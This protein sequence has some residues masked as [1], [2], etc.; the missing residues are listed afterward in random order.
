MFTVSLLKYWAQEYADRLAE[1][2]HAQLTRSSG[3]PKRK[4]HRFVIVEVKNLMLFR[5]ATVLPSNPSLHR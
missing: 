1:L 2:L 3:T 5:L 4:G